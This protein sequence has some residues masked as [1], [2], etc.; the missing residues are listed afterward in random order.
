M[1]R[2]PYLSPGFGVPPD[3][4]GYAG[5]VYRVESPLRLRAESLDCG[6][7]HRSANR[8]RECAMEIIAATFT[9]GDDRWA[10]RDVIRG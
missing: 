10:M 5:V 1:S 9:W 2:Y 8:A 7:R 6:H 4:G 3:G